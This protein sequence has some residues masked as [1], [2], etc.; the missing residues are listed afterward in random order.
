VKAEA[1]EGGTIFSFAT[2]LPG[3]RKDFWAVEAPADWSA[4]NQKGRAAAIELTDSIQ[5]SG[6]H[7][8]LG[9]VI[10]AMI[11]K[12]RFGGVEVGFCAQLSESIGRRR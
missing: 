7:P 2:V 12:G 1:L 10:G 4:A 3:G 5:A 8:L 9:A 11:E 6:A